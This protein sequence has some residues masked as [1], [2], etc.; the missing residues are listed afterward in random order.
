MNYQIL[1]ERL[2]VE[3]ER[4]ERLLQALT[5]EPLPSLPAIGH[6]EPWHREYLRV[7]RIREALERLEGRGGSAQTEAVEAS[8]PAPARDGR[9]VSS[10][11]EGAIPPRRAKPAG[12][13]SLD[14]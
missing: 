2:A 1:M 11:R 6:N 12:A 8:A 9:A 10:P 4:I 5:G 14:R 13:S 3:H 7:V